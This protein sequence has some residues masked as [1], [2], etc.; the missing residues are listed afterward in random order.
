MR[1]ELEAIAAI[2]SLSRDTREQ[3]SKSLG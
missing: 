3:V 2:P 1:A